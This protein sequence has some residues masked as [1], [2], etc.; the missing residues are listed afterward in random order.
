[1]PLGLANSDGIDVHDIV[2]VGIRTTIE[3]FACVKTRFRGIERNQRAQK[4][5]GEVGIDI[6][7]ITVDMN[8]HSC[9]S[10]H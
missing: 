1:V 5:I 9:R 3:A 10:V 6:M 2:S 4:R 8:L 7:L